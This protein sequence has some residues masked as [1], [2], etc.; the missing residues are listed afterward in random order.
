MYKED[1]RH[2]VGTVTDHRCMYGQGDK[3]NP[4]GAEDRSAVAEIRL[5]RLSQAPQN[6]PFPFSGEHFICPPV[7]DDSKSFITVHPDS[8]QHTQRCPKHPEE[9]HVK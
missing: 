9:T 1:H 5:P 8:P 4:S 3:E 6:F 2:R 7:P